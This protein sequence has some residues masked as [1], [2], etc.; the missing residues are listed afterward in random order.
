[1]PRETGIHTAPVLFQC[2]TT[3]GQDRAQRFPGSEQPEADSRKLANME[4]QKQEEVF[5]YIILLGK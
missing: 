4:K 2:S 3:W 1:M 5:F